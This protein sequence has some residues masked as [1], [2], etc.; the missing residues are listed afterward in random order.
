MSE[1]QPPALLRGSVCTPHIWFI[2]LLGRPPEHLF[3]AVECAVQRLPGWA[4][5]TKV[6]SYQLVPAAFNTHPP[7]LR[8]APFYFR[9]V[10]FVP[11]PRPPLCSEGSVLLER[12]GTLSKRVHSL[13]YFLSWLIAPQ[14]DLARTA[15][16]TQPLRRPLC[17]GLASP[18]VRQA[19][20]WEH[21]MIYSVPLDQRI[22]MCK[23]AQQ[24]SPS[25]NDHNHVS[26]PGEDKT[27]KVLW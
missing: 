15:G 8:E 2:S 27:W 23:L 4:Q 18:G 24:R 20:P 12:G 19:S 1:G 7:P 26:S 25:S 9:S 21:A 6:L 17:C 3:E 22:E 10:S 11:R 16:L 13:D 14:R 5:G